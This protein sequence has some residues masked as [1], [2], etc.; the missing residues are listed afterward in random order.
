MTKGKLINQYQEKIGVCDI[1]LNSIM[2]K[3]RKLRKEGI[4]IGDNTDEWNALC[5]ERQIISAQRQC[6]V[7]FISDIEDELD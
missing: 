3:K 1:L 5:S 2:E 6:Y 7:Q 4:V